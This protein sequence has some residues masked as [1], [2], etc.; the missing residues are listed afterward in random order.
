MRYRNRRQATEY[1]RANGIPIGRARLAQLAV[2]GEGPE[3]QYAGRYPIYT[4]A[5][6]DAWIETRLS[7]PVRSPSEATPTERGHKPKRKSRPAA[8]QHAE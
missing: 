7:A 5:A 6:L 8:E 4:E 3:Y 1:L 2:T